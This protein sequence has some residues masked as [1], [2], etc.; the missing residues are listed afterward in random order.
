MIRSL[1]RPDGFISIFKA[2]SENLGGSH[3]SRLKLVHPKKRRLY[4]AP[5]VRTRSSPPHL[6]VWLGS[7]LPGAGRD[8]PGKRPGSTIRT[9]KD[10]G[11]DKGASP[12]DEQRRKRPPPRRGGGA[13]RDGLFPGAAS[14]PGYEPRPL[15]GPRRSTRAAL[16]TASRE[17]ISVPFLSPWG[18]VR[19]TV[20]S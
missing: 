18:Q 6:G 2:I 4:I 9:S 7:I 16:S 5:A 17:V 19:L 10:D 15:R 8:K 3:A 1:S 20:L 11:K 13:V 14:A 12:W